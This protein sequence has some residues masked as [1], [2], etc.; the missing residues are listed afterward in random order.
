[1]I[2]RRIAL[3][4]V[5]VLVAVGLAAPSDAAR[6]PHVFVYDQTLGFHHQSIAEAEH[7]LRN[8][9]QLDHAFTVE[10]TQDPK[11][12]TKAALARTDVVMWLSNTAAS[13][14]SSPFTDAQEKAYEQWMLCGGGHVGVHAA[15]DSYS[16]AAF[17]AYVK[18]NGAIFKGHPITATSALDDQDH[19]NE[20]WGEPKHTLRVNDPRS[21]MTVPWRGKSTF[22]WTDELYQLDRDP[23][24]VVT[25][26]HQLLGHVSVDDPQGQVVTQVY[27]GPYADNA[28]IA[29]TGT[30]KHRNRTFYTNLGHSVLDWKNADFLRHLTS[31]VLWTAA[32]RVDKGCLRRSGIR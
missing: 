21:P 5:P 28:P 27:P 18:A 15:V 1:V 10:I 4:A 32:H 9:A 29:W 2:S 19:E 26:Y 25:G 17:P 6:V 23:S 30:Y 14:R 12:L 11:A 13:D 31:G 16:D 7:Q 3:L 22:S 20:G 24:K 8:I